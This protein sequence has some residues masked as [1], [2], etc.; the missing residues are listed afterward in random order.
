LFGVTAQA[1]SAVSAGHVQVVLG[2]SAA[3]PSFSSLS[4]GSSAASSASP[5]PSSSASASASASDNGAAGGT[6]SVSNN[7]RYGIPCI[8]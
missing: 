6:I 8:Y 4:S 7:A 3:L 2:T 5:S 1:G